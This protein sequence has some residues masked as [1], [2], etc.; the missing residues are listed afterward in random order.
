MSHVRSVRM[1]KIT[2]ALEDCV[3]SSSE[4]GGDVP[5]THFLESWHLITGE[6]PAI[7]L[8]SR[9]EMLAVLVESVPEPSLPTPDVTDTSV[10]TAE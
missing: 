2:P 3:K 10:R 6:P 9:S 7:L 1:A 5:D 4:V 8:D